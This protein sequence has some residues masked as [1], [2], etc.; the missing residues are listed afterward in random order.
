M[1]LRAKKAKRAR[2][3]VREQVADLTDDLVGALDAAREAIAR[4]S[5]AAGRRGT[6]LGAEARQAAEDRAHPDQGGAAAPE[7]GEPGQVT[8]LHQGNGA[9]TSSP[10]RYPPS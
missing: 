4:A 6:E 9:S 3:E 8:Q 10:T 7:A 1:R 2:D 5:A